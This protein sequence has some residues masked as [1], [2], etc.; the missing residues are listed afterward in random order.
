MISEPWTT[1]TALLTIPGGADLGYCA[2]LNGEGN[3]RIRRFLENGGAYL[4]FCAGGYY[5]SAECEFES[6]SKK[7]GM[8][9]IGRRELGFFPGV[10]RG[11][12][13]KGF[14][15]GSENGARAVRLTTMKDSFEQIQQLPGEFRSYY[16]GGGVFV[17]AD[18]FS[19]KGIEVL[20]E[21]KDDLDVDHG[22]GRKAAIVFCKIGE[23]AAILTGPH[24]ES[25]IPSP[26]RYALI[27]NRFASINLKPKSDTSFFPE[28]LQKVES[29]DDARSEFIAACLIK[30]GLKVNRGQN[31]V[32][33]LSPLH[34]SA[35]IP[36][37]V[38][39][40]RHELRD[41]VSI[42]G[43][44][45]ILKD[46][47]DTFDIIMDSA[48]DMSDLE[49][50]LVE[51]ETGNTQDKTTEYEKIVKRLI[52]HDRNYPS[53]SLTPQF[54]HELYYRYQEEYAQSTPGAD[55]DFG[56]WLLYGEVVTS[57]NSLLEK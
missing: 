32:P 28:L 1:S 40:I 38:S 15:Y 9:I 54:D 52:F 27:R 16:N 21:Y 29:N 53:L 3:R 33:T 4:G 48:L 41:I 12:A 36:E 30:L 10:C 5:G 18:R 55:P 39:E 56:N 44:K 31:V 2:D 50:A 42:D 45:K 20:A 46:E 17:D 19:D 6:G 23:G 35:L 11:A 25:V 47:Q 7:K 34:F 22:S 49:K 8:E 43:D 51:S 26:H 14:E 37:A 13:F 24:P 57:T